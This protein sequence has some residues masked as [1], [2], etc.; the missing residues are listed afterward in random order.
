MKYERM[1]RRA[2]F[3]D[4]MIVWYPLRTECDERII[5]TSSMGIWMEG[6]SFDVHLCEFEMEQCL[7]VCFIDLTVY[8]PHFRLAATFKQNALQRATVVK[9]NTK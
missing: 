3:R 9:T 7:N 5:E 1:V 4:G 2:D 6:S 8:R